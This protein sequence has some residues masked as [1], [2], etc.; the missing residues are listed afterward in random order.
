MTPNPQDTDD[1]RASGSAGER[2]SGV[3]HRVLALL[4]LLYGVTYLDRVCISVAAPVM[5]R[6]FGF[7]QTGK[8][9]V[10][11]AFQISYA[12][13]QIPTGWLADRVGARRVLAV[14]VAWWSFSTA[15]TG[16]A[17]NLVS[18]V[19]IRFLFGMGEAGAFPTSSRAMA[20]WMG[21]SE[22]GFAQGITHTGSRLVGAMAQPL[23]G[24]LIRR[25]GWRDS[26]G[27]YGIIGLPWIIIWSTCFR[28][29]PEEHP[30]VN[31]AELGKLSRRAVTIPAFLLPALG[32]AGGGLLT[33]PLSSFAFLLLAVSALELTTGVSWAVALDLGKEKSETV[34]GVMNTFGNLG[35]A[36][37]H[38]AIGYSVDYLG[39][40]TLPL[41][42]AAIL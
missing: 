22:R 15:A 24:I 29:R 11:S 18:L 3:R 38:L 12:L 35:G 33:S 32:L 23:S 2:P 41:L 5:Q 9:F 19:V 10:F 36:V 7:G 42:A 14:L 40:W 1:K 13:F 16:A 26:F 8:S 39:S 31:A 20:R 37:P 25:L 17:W 30:Q 27:L 4:V 28:D 21:V 6:D 34:S